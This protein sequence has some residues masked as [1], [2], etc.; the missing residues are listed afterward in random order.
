VDLVIGVAR[1][2]EHLGEH[3]QQAV[4]MCAQRVSGDLQAVGIGGRGQ[5]C[6]G[7]LHAGGYLLGLTR[8]GS[9]E[10]RLGQ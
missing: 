6:A 7:R 2:F 3:F 5:R 10:Q 9:G 1:R 8:F 4:E